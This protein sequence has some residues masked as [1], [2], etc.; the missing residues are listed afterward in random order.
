[1]TARRPAARR[2]AHAAADAAAPLAAERDERGRAHGPRALLRRGPAEV[3][4]ALAVL[5]FRLLADVALMPFLIAA[6]SAPAV[7]AAL[8]TRRLLTGPRGLTVPSGPYSVNSDLFS[9]S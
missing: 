5:N 3:A 9:N 6:C 1:M 2:A 8:R 4:N 7:L